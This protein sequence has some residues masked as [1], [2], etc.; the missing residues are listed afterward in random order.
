MS[1]ILISGGGIAGLTC[2]YWL[3]RQGH[4]PIVIEKA[5]Q[6]RKEGYLID[7]VGT[8]WDVANRMNL[9]PQLEQ[10]ALPVSGVRYP[11]SQG[12]TAARFDLDTL[13][14]AL[15]ITD[16]FMTLNRADL[17]EVLYDAVKNDVEVRFDCSIEHINQTAKAV[18]ATL[19]GG[20]QET[21]ELLVGADG[22]HSNTRELV[23]GNEAE[24]AAYLGYQVATCII[25]AGIAIG[26]DLVTYNEPD[27]Q[28]NLYR[29]DDDEMLAFFIYKAA[30]AGHVPQAKRKTRLQAKFAGAE[31]R[32]PEMLAMIA[33]D[34]PIFMDTVTQIM[35]PTWHNGRIVLIGDA[36]YCL[37]LISGQGAS[38][39]MGGAY[40]L[41]QALQQ[42]PD[43]QTAFL[44]YE[45]RLR[46]TIEETQ[47]KARRFAPRFVPG[48]QFQIWLNNRIVKLSNI[49]FFSRII[50]KQFN[51][52]SLL[53]TAEND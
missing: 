34:T 36:A 8:G 47:E 28:A 20:Q 22:I 33:D 15:N 2:A 10:K 16:K 18:T 3:H 45:N 48:S 30:D 13:K 35:M 25:P 41:A 9:V 52:K 6:L 40:F 26:D 51:T 44:Q 42:S 5:K 53:E 50:G 19:T 1:K 12:E 7:F 31:W 4:Q 27:R 39:A 11:N 24:F 49:S 14:K 21:F 32:L 29:V 38:M 17:E 37:T 43:Y 46:P 23:F